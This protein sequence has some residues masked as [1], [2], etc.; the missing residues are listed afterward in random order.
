[1]VKKKTILYVFPW[2]P[3]TVKIFVLG[4]HLPVLRADLA[5]NVF[6]LFIYF[7][8][9]FPVK[10]SRTIATPSRHFTR[11]EGIVVMSFSFT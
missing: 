1:M 6:Y 8:N 9:I 10:E 11:P 5:W 7:L 4:N 2:S 3:A